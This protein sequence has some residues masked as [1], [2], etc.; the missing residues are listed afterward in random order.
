MTLFVLTSKADLTGVHPVGFVDATLDEVAKTFGE[1]VCIE[2]HRGW[3]FSSI[4]DGRPVTL[5]KME[6]AYGLLIGAYND[7]TVPKFVA[8]LSRLLDEGKKREDEGKKRENQDGHG[9]EEEENQN[10]LGRGLGRGLG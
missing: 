6:G 5:Y 10:G 9:L 8:W 1:P 7:S 4:R 3:M 2:K